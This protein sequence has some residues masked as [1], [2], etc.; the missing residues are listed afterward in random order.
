VRPKKAAR[1]PRRYAPGGWSRHVIPV[2]VFVVAHPGGICLFD[3][4][5]TARSR[6]PGYH[7]RWHPFHR[8]ARFELEPE[9]EAAPQLRRSGIEPGDVRWVALSHLHTDHIG[10]LAPFVRS[11][12]LVTRTEWERAQGLA[13]QLRGYLPQHWPP[14]LQPRLVDFTG[15][16][17]GPFRAS[18]D[19]AGDGRLVLVPAP[20]HTEGHAALLV[21]GQD[22]DFLLAGDAAKTAAELAESAPELARFCHR[23]G[24]VILTAHDERAAQLLGDGVVA[25]EQRG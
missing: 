21:R 24:I 6:L 10:G 25:Q 18:F 4:G 14:G 19:I 1:G 23:E 7:P 8:L 2:N 22:R 5:Q 20:G 17:V 15:P 9:D 3:A 12:V 11:E 16:A 13:G